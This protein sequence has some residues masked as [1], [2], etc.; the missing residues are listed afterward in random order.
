MIDRINKLIEINLS[1]LFTSENNTLNIKDFKDDTGN[2]LKHAKVFAGI[3]QKKE[4][5]QNNPNEEFSFELTHY[6]KHIAENGG[7]IKHLEKLKKKEDQILFED[8]Q[9]T[10]IETKQFNESLFIASF[11][12][13][14]LAF[15]MVLLYYQFGQK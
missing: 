6:G 11:I 13:V 14:L 10:E 8:F 2:R 12:I 1:L 5:I 15:L 7:W 3:M 4:L 9:N